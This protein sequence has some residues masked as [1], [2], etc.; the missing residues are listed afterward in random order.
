MLEII[1]LIFL[2]RHIGEI[3]IRKGESANKWKLYTVLAWIGG[4]ITGLI[5]GFAIFDDNTLMSILVAIP[6]AVAGYHI[7]RN[8]LNRKPD[9]TN[10][11]D[12]I[13]Q[14]LQS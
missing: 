6:C 14:D 13:G 7:V 12:E 11:I 4:E 3:A 2:C 8:Q 5:I 1:I 10:M 9:I